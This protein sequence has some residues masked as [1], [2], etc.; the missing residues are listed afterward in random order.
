MRLERPLINDA[1]NQIMSQN[2]F[3]L[4]RSPLHHAGGKMIWRYSSVF[5]QKG[6]LE[7]DLN[8]MYRQPLWPINMSAPHILLE[9]VTEIPVLDIHELA[10]GKLSALFSRRASRDLFDAHYLLK[11]CK[12]DTQK[13]RTSFVIYLAM[14][15]IPMLNLDPRYIEYDLIDIRHRLFPVL[16][17]EALPRSQVSLKQWASDIRHEL[18]DALSTLLPLNKSE[19]QFIVSIR[20]QGIIRPELITDDARLINVVKT[21][22]AIMWMT[23]K[24]EATKKD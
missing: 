10:A 11:K 23:K 13:L 20:E 7:I 14:T 18:H 1:I 22:P 24:N 19:I 12:I 3:E 4:D 8:Y 17:Q 5:G 15:E 2:H 6:N 21:H 16:R 9:K